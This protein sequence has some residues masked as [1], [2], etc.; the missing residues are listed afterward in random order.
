VPV[1]LFRP[2][3]L[4]LLALTLVA[5][6][7]SSG[8]DDKPTAASST[9]AASL[10]G[11]TVTGEAGKA[12]TIALAKTPFTVTSTVSKVITPGTGATVAKGQKVQVDYLLVDGRDGKEKDTTFGK[13]SVSFTADPAKLLPGLATGLINNKIGSR[14][15]VAI[16]P[17]DAFGDQGNTDLGVEKNDTLLFVLDLKSATTPLTK[18]T[19]TTVAPKPGLPTV[20]DDAK[21]T[22]TVTLPSGAAPTRLVSQPLIKGNGPVV[23]SGQS[24]T[25]NYVGV[26]WPGGKIFDSSY[27]KGSTA[28]FVIGQGQVIKG[29]DQGLVGQTVGSRML[30]V[31]PPDLGYGAQGNT[32]AGIKGSDTLVFVVDVLDAS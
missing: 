11:V 7:S 16:P 1:R 8:K 23:K 27:A 19:G 3:L 15:L 17:A 12:P 5:G 30:L 4:S 28:E 18:P 13:K 9:R 26:I 22:P 29:W 20:K 6:C 24:L 25:V 21:G 14:V 31:I 2:A 32:Q 10:D